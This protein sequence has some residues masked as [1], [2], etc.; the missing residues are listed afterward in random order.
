MF[1]D[2]QQVGDDDVGSLQIGFA[3]G[4][5]G[6]V[7]GPFGGSMDGDGQAGEILR[8]ARRDA[9]SRACGM[10]IKRDHNDVV[11]DLCACQRGISAHN[12][13]WP[14]KGFRRKSQ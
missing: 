11:A 12:G 2:E 6:G 8:Q 1:F 7:F 5:G 9:C 10:L 3:A 13:L 4:K 14:R